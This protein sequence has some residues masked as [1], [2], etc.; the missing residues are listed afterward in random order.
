MPSRGVKLASARVSRFPDGEIST[1]LFETVLIRSVHH[2]GDPHRRVNESLR[3]SWCTW[4]HVG[5]RAH[6][7]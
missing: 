2:P 1:E 6:A 3:S 5:A 7:A 4:T